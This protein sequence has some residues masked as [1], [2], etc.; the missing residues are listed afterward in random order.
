MK[1]L[2]SLFTSLILLAGGA[3]AQDPVEVPFFMTFIPNVQFSPVYVAIENGYFAEDGLSVT[4]E[5]GDEPVG[6]D[7]IAAGQRQFGLIS[8]EQVLAARANGRPVVS[9]Y[10]WF[11]SYPIGIVIP[12]PSDITTPADLVG[13]NVG[14]PGR[15]GASYSGLLALLAAND[16]AE[17]DI[18]LEEIG[19]NAPEVVCVGGVEASVVYV[20]NEPLQIADRAQSGDCGDV[21]GVRVLNVSDYVD[22]VSNGVVT[23]EDTISNQPE[24]VQGVVAGFAAGLVRAIENPAE[25][26]LVSAN[27]VD[28]L[29]L[30]DDL[31]TALESLVV[32]QDAWLASDAYTDRAALAERRDAMLAALAETIPAADLTQFRVL[33]AT[34]TLWDADALGLADTASWEVTQQVL[35]DMGAIS[36]AQDVEAAFTNAFL[37][38]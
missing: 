6:V 17:S 13:R 5:H 26:Y 1:H 2:I 18:E 23:N 36:E 30:S 19:F 25:A 31:R 15:F 22:M 12:E 35:L 11:Q 21:T 38:E 29:P 14:I 34:I 3:A 16:L 8:G 32:E 9:V 27:F 37:P 28:N 7:L 20:N 24:L 4:I 10:E 33:L